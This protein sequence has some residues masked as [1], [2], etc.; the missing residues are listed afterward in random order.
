[1]TGIGASQKEKDL[2]R[3]L[4]RICGSGF[5]KEKAPTRTSQ[6]CTKPAYEILSENQVRFTT[7]SATGENK[8]SQEIKN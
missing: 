6:V 5:L 1:M 8:T 4:Y 3:L 2:T 7:F